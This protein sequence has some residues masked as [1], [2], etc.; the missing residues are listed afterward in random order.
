[1]AK[2]DKLIE[3]KLSHDE[4]CDIINGLTIRAMSQGLDK[5]AKSLGRKLS[6]ALKKLEKGDGEKA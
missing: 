5:E 6:K 1:M 3:V 2:T 4:I